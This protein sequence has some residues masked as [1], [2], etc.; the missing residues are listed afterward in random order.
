[1][2][3]DQQEQTEQTE[4]SG[5][6]S[7]LTV[8]SVASCWVPVA[9]RVTAFAPVRECTLGGSGDDWLTARHANQAKR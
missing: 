6:G 9:A 2:L 5:K 1:M 7:L 4:R 3:K 8:V